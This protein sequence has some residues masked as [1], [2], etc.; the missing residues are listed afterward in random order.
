[1]ASEDY[2]KVMVD[3]NLAGK[4]KRST[5]DT[6]LFENIYK[7]KVYLVYD[8]WSWRSLKTPSI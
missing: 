6:G 8:R 7:S 5:V 4:K 3:Y 2:V 1:M